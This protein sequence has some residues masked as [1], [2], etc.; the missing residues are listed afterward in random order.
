M[1]MLNS[2]IFISV[3]YFISFLSTSPIHFYIKRRGRTRKRGCFYGTHDLQMEEMNTEVVKRVTNLSY[4]DE[5]SVMLLSSS[6]LIP[7]EKFYFKYIIYRLHNNIRLF[8]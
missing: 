5:D 3:I 2:I 7:S 1:C 4:K 8:I 6:I